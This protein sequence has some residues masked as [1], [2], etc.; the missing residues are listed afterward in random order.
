MIYSIASYLVYTLLIGIFFFS[1]K[2]YR[3]EGSIVN[4]REFFLLIFLPS[5][6]YGNWLYNRELRLNGKTTFPKEWFIWK[7]IIPIN[8]SYLIALIISG[9]ILYVVIAG[10]IDEEL[11]GAAK[12]DDLISFG[13]DVFAIFASVMVF[14]VAI[15]TS[16]LLFGIYAMILL[17][18]PKYLVKSI[19][20]KHFQKQA[21]RNKNNHQSSN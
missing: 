18:I 4:K 19:E 10:M 6:G 8:I 13:F 12:P 2:Y 20:K 11:N 9:I 21:E 5:I 1:I 14:S 17:F 16:I 7:K 15:F 3:T